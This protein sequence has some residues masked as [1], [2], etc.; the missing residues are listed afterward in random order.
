MNMQKRILLIVILL[1]ILLMGIGYAS[2]TNN[3]LIINGEATALGDNSNFKVYFTGEVP[4]TYSSESHI[5]VD[6]KPL[7]QSQTSTVNIL[8]LSSK[9]DSA[10][11]ILEIENASADIDA[12]SITVT[13]NAE[14]NDMFEIDVIMCDIEGNAITNYAV[15]A[16]QK[17]YV[18]IFTELLKTA[19][20]DISTNINAQLTASPK[21]SSS[22]NPPDNPDVPI[23]TDLFGEYYAKAEEKLLT[24]TLD[25]K[26]AQM[27]I[28]G[29]SS[30]TNYALLNQYQFG[31]HLYLLDSFKDTSG[32]VLKV[33]TLKNQ[34]QES[35]SK[36]KIPLL[37]AIDEEGETVSRINSTIYPELK[38]LNIMPH[39]FQNSCDIYTSGGL[40]AIKEDTIYK[41]SI[42]KYLGFNLNFAPDV[43]IAD[44]GFYIYKR[45]LKQDAQTTSEFAKTVIKT[46]KNTGVSYSLKHFPGYGNS[47]DTH[48]GFSTDNRNL[49]EFE[50]KDLIPFK[51][52][53]EAGAEIVMI[54]HN[55]I[56]CLDDNEPASISKAVHDYLRNNMNFTGIIITDAINMDAVAKKYS[57]KDSVIKAIQS[58]NDLI[59]ISMNEGQKDTTG[60]VTLTYQGIINY[61]SEAI[62]NE[63]ISE[64]TVNTSVKRILAWKYYKGLIQD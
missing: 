23:S 59:C 33:N 57:T 55:I 2:L 38:T 48:N 49:S 47:K 28:I 35:Q 8:G 20:E 13:T 15:P 31:G 61:I 53:I 41:S 37:M 60:G 46:G 14:S 54:S 52:G 30:S 4:K 42:L 64:D 17:T 10:Y 63:Q 6:A 39:A 24:M 58:G 32:N 36:S 11:A 45:T 16:G 12:E 56:T 44:A 19:T 7:A 50:N 21:D 9:G 62:A 26:I 3:I 18:K 25:E 1:I 51:G 27:Y 34:I 40:D 29:T 5:I 43:D 22:G